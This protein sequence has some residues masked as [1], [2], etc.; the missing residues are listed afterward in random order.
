MLKSKKFDMLDDDTDYKYLT[1]MTM[2]SVTDESVDKLSRQYNEKKCE[3]ETLKETTTEQMW[4]RELEELH[5]EY[6]KHR[7]QLRLANSGTDQNKKVTKKVIIKKK[8]AV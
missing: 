8:K 6:T 2:D 4:Q 1:K 5:A 3:L 7:E